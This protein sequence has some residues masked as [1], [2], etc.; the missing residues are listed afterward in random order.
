MNQREIEA[1]TWVANNRGVMT[2]IARKVAP[3]VSPQFVH[4]VL[5][6][7]RSSRD[8]QIERMLRKAGAPVI[9]VES[10]LKGLPA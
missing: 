6:G 9:V 10:K 3:R 1:L 5:R 7:K 4:L 8:G 2:Q